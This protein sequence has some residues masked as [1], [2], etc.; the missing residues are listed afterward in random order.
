MDQLEKA[1]KTIN[2]I[3]KEMAELFES[4]MKAVEEVVDYKIKNNKEVL[5]QTREKALIEN[6]LS[7][8][9]EESLKESYLRYLKMT[10]EISRD[11]QKRIMNKDRIGYGGTI[12]AFSHIAA[13]QLFPNHH[14][15]AYTTFEEIVK[16]VETNEL[17]YGVIPFENSFTGEVVETSDILRDYNVYIHDMYDLKITQN[18]LGI[19]GTKL[20]DIK[21]VYS[22]P[23]GLSQCSLFLKGFDVK[24]VAYPNTALAAE[25]VSR[26]NDKS[27]AAIASIETAKLFNLE[28]IEENI[29]TS[30]DNTTRFIVISKKLK[31]EGNMFQMLFTVNNE[32]GA[33][34]NA[35]NCIAKHHFNMKS[36]KSRAIPNEPWS[37]Y[38]HVEIEGNLASEEA[39]IMLKDLKK[40]CID[41]KLLGGYTKKEG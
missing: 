35:M 17:E 30:S 41:L 37:Y 27:K 5:D 18:L 1:R 32:T 22:H 2:Q 11:Y 3:D 10:L 20:S 12:G 7:Y 13:M 29:N 24:T 9:K 33:L 15:Q 31:E 19:Q 16:A 4:R 23:Q 34:A 25:Y 14:L 36:I 26:K 8:V 40:D 21:E 6:N 39:K 28:V 38:F